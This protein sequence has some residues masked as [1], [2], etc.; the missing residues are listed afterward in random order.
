MKKIIFL[1]LVLVLTSCD[2]SLIKIPTSPFKDDKYERIGVN[3]VY[4]IT[5]SQLTDDEFKI[6]TE[7]FNKV[8]NP[9]D[10][11]VISYDRVEETRDLK[12][13]YFGKEI[14]SVFFNSLLSRNEN[15]SEYL[16]NVTISKI[17]SHQIIQ[18]A[19]GDNN[20][21]SISETYTFDTGYKNKNLDG[22]YKSHLK[23]KKN[24]EEEIVTCTT[25]KDP[26][27]YDLE[28]EKETSA[29][30]GINPFVNSIIPLFPTDFKIL[31]SNAVYGKC[32]DMFLVKEAYSVY[33][34]NFTTTL[35]RQYL[36]V[37]NYFYE[38]RLKNYK[39]NDEPCLVIND[40]RFYHETLILSESFSGTG[41]PI[42]YLEKPVLVWFDEIKYNFTYGAKENYVGD[43]PEVTVKL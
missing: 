21:N 3:S 22:E 20:T 1:P 16:N 26:I 29:I 19:A 8:N 14:S 23:T 43:I 4:K 13:A 6:L 17:N 27:K 35:G 37:D 42:L 38:T 39:N 34:S 11:N 5:D 36:A 18:M 15:I 9:T 33:N 25:G 41:V 24:D 32:D 30:F 10:N 2:S 12:Y 28:I 40:F 7:A 31:G